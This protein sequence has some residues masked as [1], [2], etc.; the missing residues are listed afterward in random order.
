MSNS[1]KSRLMSAVIFAAVSLSLAAQT[2]GAAASTPAAVPATTAAS[3]TAAAASP[4]TA[5]PAKAK[6]PSAWVLGLAQFSPTEAG[7]STSILLSDLPRLIVADLKSLPARRVPEED[8]SES[9][10]L[11]TLRARFAAGTDLA[12]KLDARDLSFLD[13][14]LEGEAKK[15]GMLTAKKNVSDSTKKLE[16][17][18]KEESHASPTPQAELATEL[19]DGHATGRLIDPPAF[20][21]PKAAKAA[22][23]DL[24]VTGS[25]AL[26]SGYAKVVLRG[27][28]AS[29]GREVFAWK[30]HCSI[31][32]P[33]PLAEEMAERLERW[34]AGREFARLELKPN[35][36]SAELYVNGELVSGSTRV[37]YIYKDGPVAISAAASGYSPYSTSLELSLGERRAIELKLE[38]LS[39]GTVA[40]TTD[41]PGSSIS[42]DSVPLGPSPLSI[43]LN[44]SR[45]IV[46][47]SSEGR[48]T[49]TIVLPESGDSS[50][51]LSL[52]PS[53]GLG[54]AGRISAAKDRFYATLGW[55][56]LS[57]PVTALSY[58][59]Y[60]S[61]DEAYGRSG[62]QSMYDSRTAAS[63]AVGI[64]A[65]ATATTAAFMIVRL[66]K[67]LK[68]AR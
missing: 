60:Y 46:S 47:A 31:D 39:T 64:A 6:A 44:G 1:T 34:T 54:P 33:E 28:D 5:V 25:V 27:Y 26:G 3:P 36:S 19:W 56:V 65:A 21:L 67:Y 59:A 13:P 10:G 37:A 61:Y 30:S 14:S 16:D 55:F 11:N 45:S 40:L 50:I 43:S 18:T 41:P 38:P 49:Q 2:T 29:L 62:L 22:G 63:V 42:L 7:D 48:E 8:A 53:D 4:A 15:V 51:D 17:A 23:V 52:L 20:D 57:I 9:A 58:G 66:I 32:D 35:P 12:A 24:L 68:S